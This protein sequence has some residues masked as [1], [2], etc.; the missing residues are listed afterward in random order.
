MPKTK[1]KKLAPVKKPKTASKKKEAVLVKI[2][3]EEPKKTIVAANKKSDYLYATGRRKRSIARV[4]FLKKGEGEITVND[5]PYQNYFNY[6]VYQNIINEPLLLTN[7]QKQGAYSI[8]VTGGGVRGQ[9]DAISLGIS[10]IL[11]QLDPNCRPLL[12]T[13]KLLTRDSRVKERK[14]YGLKKARRAPQWQ[15][16]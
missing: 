12:K 10:R 13:Q 16:R 14:K 4:R 8:K 15:K 1:T 9:A 3:S 7:T 11:V 2:E 5:K 6:F